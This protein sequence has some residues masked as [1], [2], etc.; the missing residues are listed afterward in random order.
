MKGSWGQEEGLWE[1]VGGRRI[2]VS[3]LGEDG[4]FTIPY[5]PN[6]SPPPPPPASPASHALAHPEVHQHASTYP[7]PLRNFPL[8]K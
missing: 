3:K 1:G 5:P 6:L 8:G 4:L 7:P 2:E